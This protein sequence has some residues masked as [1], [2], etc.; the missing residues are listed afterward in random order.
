MNRARRHPRHPDQSDECGPDR[1]GDRARAFSGGREARAASRL[2][3]RNVHDARG[4]LWALR[5]WFRLRPLPVVFDHFGGAQ[6]ALGVHQP[7]FDDL[8]E[9]VR[10][11]KANVKISGVYRAS[12]QPDYADVKPL[13]QALIAAN[14]DRIIWGSD[15]PHPHA[16]SAEPAI[17]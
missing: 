10:S 3:Y 1:S 16:G 6:A 11:G 5:I 15:W 4:D 7:G 13:A 9:L 17:L 8:V 12:T 2:A 14:A